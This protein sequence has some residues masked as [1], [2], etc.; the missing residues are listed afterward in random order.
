MNTDLVFWLTAFSAVANTV[1][2]LC[3]VWLWK[4]RND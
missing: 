1:S 3:N 2:L 4:V